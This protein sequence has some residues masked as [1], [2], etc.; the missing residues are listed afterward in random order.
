MIEKPK[1]AMIIRSFNRGGA[2][3]LIRELF[4]NK[5]FNEKVESCDLVILDSKRIELLKDLKNVNYYI[6]NV[7][8]SSFF[9]FFSEYNKLYRFIK[10][11]KYSVLHTHLPNAAILVRFIKILMPKIKIVYS[12]QNVVDSYN[13]ISF[14][15]NG[16]TYSKDD[17]IIFASPEVQFSVN[18]HKRSG[19]YNYKKGSVIM[20]AVDTNKFNITNKKNLYEKNYLIVGTVVSFRKWKRLDRWIEVVEVIKKN[21]PDIPI[22]FIMAGIGPEK[23]MVEDLISEKK[24]N[25]YIDLP[26]LIIDTVCIYNK[27]DIFLMTSEFEGLPVALLEAMSCGCIPVTSNAGGIRN[28]NFNGFG[29]KYDNFN[30]EEL[31]KII[32]QYYNNKTKII[33]EGKKAR[34]LI[35]ENHSF[36]KMVLEYI[37]IYNNLNYKTSD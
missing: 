8:S 24:L 33:E 3:V 23:K 20:N 19:F 35:L 32:F 7:F 34:E 11:K 27:L 17:H 12:E 26:G 22:K 10:E 31:A 29:Y 30:A 2:E 14:L 15:L 21:Y 9:K 36:D 18:K 4:K 28:L 25:A 1:I 13:K 6:I 16:L 5:I 37:N